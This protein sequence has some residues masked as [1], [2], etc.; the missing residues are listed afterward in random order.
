MPRATE[1]VVDTLIEAGID[2]V[3]G[4]PGGATLF[5]FDALFDRQDRIR[6]V[7]A[8]QEGGAACMADMYGRLTGKPGVVIGQGAW[9]GSNA[10]FAVMEAYLAGSP[11]L[12]L[13]DV[14]DYAG[15]IQHGPYQCAGGEYGSVNLPNIM[16][17]MTKYTTVANS[18]SEFV[19]GT[20]LAIKHAVTGRPGP[21]CVLARWDV[22]TSEIERDSAHP[23]VYPLAGHLSVSPPCISA[24]DA[25][26][27]AEMLLE[28]KNPV[29]IAGR[30]VHVSRAYKE[31]QELAE[32]LGLPVATSYM[33]KSAI[34][35]THELA[36]GTMGNIGQ[37]LANEMISA[38]DVLLAVGTGL[39]PE[40][41]R[42]LSP[43]FIN[44]E[45]QKIVHID[46][47]PLN[48]GWTFP[49]AIGVASDAKVAL[50][51]IID[52]LKAR[53]VKVD[54]GA[55]VLELK[56]L[57]AEHDFFT[58]EWYGSDEEPIAPE[59]IVSELNDALGADGLLVLDGGNNRMWCAKH[60]RSKT[61]GQVVAPGGAAGVGWSVPASLAAQ[62]ISPERKVA[63][64]CG[65]GG[66]M[67][68]LYCLGM[69]KEY[70]LPLTYVVMNNS[71]LGNVRDF[72]SPERRIATEYPETDFAGIARSVGCKGLRIEKPGELKSALKAALESD[73]P[74]LI[75]V[76]TSREAHFRLMM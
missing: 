47:E 2:H 14:S 10:A 31:V 49:V 12:I 32:L 53:K 18:A 3:F 71:S 25:D 4:L 5:I 58:C 52:S 57:K 64:V 65:D 9:M 74:A 61:A 23:R 24:D 66:M 16:R 42:M 45:R 67:M 21:T 48:A 72:Q 38:A 15:L 63:C 76:V 41:T 43:D 36:L 68:M 20:Q 55:K 6:T 34:A 19:H 54:V 69:A 59:R 22:M 17:S 39:S 51:A 44:P 70:E 50:R 1:A 27:V 56:K 60:F 13:G 28:A 11:M 8:R 73:K 46:I 40:N 30:G 33:G 29:M 37:R 62:M 75:D 7:L 35:E 26:R